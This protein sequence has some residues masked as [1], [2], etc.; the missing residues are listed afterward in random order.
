MEYSST[1]MAN[2]DIVFTQ[3]D[4]ITIDWNFGDTA[5]TVTLGLVPEPAEA[6]AVLGAIAAAL[7]ALRRRK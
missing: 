4:G 6:A 3:I 7:A 2:S 5:L 1:D